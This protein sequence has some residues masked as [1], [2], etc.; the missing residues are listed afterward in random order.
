M[1]VDNNMAVIE[2]VDKFRY[3]VADNR[4]LS[5]VAVHRVFRKTGRYILQLGYVNFLEQLI[6]NLFLVIHVWNREKEIYSEAESLHLQEKAIE[7]PYLRTHVSP[8]NS[9]RSKSDLS[10]LPRNSS[11]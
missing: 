3:D 1:F 4:R 6:M 5:Q 10:F 9:M 2:D 8:M 11:C 7:L